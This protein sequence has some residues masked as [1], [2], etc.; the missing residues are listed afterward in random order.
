MKAVACKCKL[1]GKKVQGVPSVKII[2]WKTKK[3]TNRTWCKSNN[4]SRFVSGPDSEQSQ[5]NKSN[6]KTTIKMG[7]DEFNTA[8]QVI[9]VSNVNSPNL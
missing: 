9:N 5:R 1:W 2:L 3:Q 4:Q 6:I 8:V 7:T